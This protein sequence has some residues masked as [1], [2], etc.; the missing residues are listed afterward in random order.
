MQTLI[1]IISI[2]LFR[3]TV[4]AV[5]HWFYFTPKPSIFPPPPLTH[6]PYV[7][8]IFG[9]NIFCMLLHLIF[10]PP[11]AG[12][13]TRGFLHGGLMID[14]VGQQSPVSRLKLLGLD[15][16]VMALQVVLLG[17]ALEQ[18]N[19]RSG[20]SDRGTEDALREENADS[21]P[22]Q[23]HDSEE[24]GMLRQETSAEDD[25]ELQ[26]L[27]PSSSGRTG[28][29]EDRERNELLKPER[30]NEQQGR[31]P[32]DSFSTGEHVITNLHIL[33]TIRTQWRVTELSAASSS[34]ATTSASD[35]M[36]SPAYSFLIRTRAGVAK[37]VSGVFTPL[38]PSGRS[39]TSSNK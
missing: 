4:R 32:L 24:R 39:I 20:S 15:L 14:F 11:T 12:E 35:G 25:I 22:Q 36:S 19:N 9:T 18:R 5:P 7:G 29:D 3:F 38:L 6:R 1:S 16:L 17:V 8:L 13:A 23:D 28:G 2:S 37:H 27:A 34:A 30:S 21:L 10:I 33:D 31:H 26:D